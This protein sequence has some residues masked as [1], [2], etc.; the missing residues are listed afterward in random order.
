MADGGPLDPV[1][2][3]APWAAGEERAL[4]V[5]IHKARDKATALAMRSE[6]RNARHLYWLAVEVAGSR[7]F[8]RV[9]EDELRETLKA[10]SW[11][12]LLAG[13]IEARDAPDG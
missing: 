6:H 11:A 5:R 9:T 3:F 12:F 13:W 2:V 7:V 8:A 4:R 10:V 1:A